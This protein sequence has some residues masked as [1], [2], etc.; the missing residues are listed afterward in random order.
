M[1][2]KH[3]S[4]S[5]SNS[6]TSNMNSRRTLSMPDCLVNFSPNDTAMNFVDYELQSSL[7]QQQLQANKK[8]KLGNEGISP[9]HHHILNGEQQI[10]FSNQAWMDGTANLN[11]QQAMIPSSQT[12]FDFNAQ[13]DGLFG[14]GDNGHNETSYQQTNSMTKHISL[15]HYP[16]LHHTQIQL[17]E[18]LQM[19][20][21]QNHPQQLEED[22]NDGMVVTAPQIQSNSSPNEQGLENSPQFHQN[23]MMDQQQEVAPSQHSTSFGVASSEQQQ[24]S[25]E[26][27]DHQQ[28]WNDIDENGIFS[29]VDHSE[30]LLQDLSGDNTTT[31]LNNLNTSSSSDNNI[32]E[33][34]SPQ[35]SNE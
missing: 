22:G 21:N 18:T 16:Q 20:L 35:P 25:T 10:M 4:S 24:P 19:I 29:P 15:N 30:F 13:Q 31:T 33:N 2:R 32:I 6:S 26:Y 23:M 11:Q 3:T 14:F 34:S 17:L 9:T 27:Q 28:L 7:Y 1:K 12:F 5:S 8:C